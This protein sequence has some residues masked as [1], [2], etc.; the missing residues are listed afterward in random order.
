VAVA[1]RARLLMAATEDRLH[2]PYRLP[3]VP[4]S[5]ALVERLR[6]AGVASVLSGSGPT[7]L[8]LAV[9]GAQA[10]TAVGVP[11]PGFAVLPLAVDRDGLRVTSAGSR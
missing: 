3:A 2:Q 7:V 8:A 10:A 1:A 9:G 5:A 11:A 4:E 6:V